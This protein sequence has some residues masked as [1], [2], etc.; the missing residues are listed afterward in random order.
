MV[1]HTL[2]TVS[3]GT[4]KVMKRGPSPDKCG[5]DD[6]Q[7]DKQE[8]GETAQYRLPGRELDIVCLYSM[9]KK[10][11]S[12]KSGKA[13]WQKPLAACNPSGSF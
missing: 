4:S 2:P 3:P 10:W 8:S 6:D 12:H 13:G 7:M 1:S 5:R 9:A 11:C